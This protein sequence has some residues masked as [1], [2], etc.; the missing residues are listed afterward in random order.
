MW[1]VNCKYNLK[2]YDSMSIDILAKINECAIR[3][4]IIVVYLFQ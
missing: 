1:Y 2:E 3:H 4:M